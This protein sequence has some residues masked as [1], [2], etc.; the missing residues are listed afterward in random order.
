[1]LNTVK[2]NETLVWKLQKKPPHINSR[3]VEYACFDQET[4]ENIEFK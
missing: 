2:K 3:T 4:P 1:M